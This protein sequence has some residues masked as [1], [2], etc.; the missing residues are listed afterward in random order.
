MSTRSVRC[1]RRARQAARLMLVVVLPQPP[2]WL[3]IAIVR[4]DNLPWCSSRASEPF[5]RLKM[6][7]DS[8]C[9]LPQ[10]PIGEVSAET[11]VLWDRFD[12]HG[13]IRYFQSPLL[14]FQYDCDSDSHWHLRLDL[15]SLARDF[16]SQNSHAKARIG[17][18]Q[19][20]A[21]LH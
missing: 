3:M 12:N 7:P 9:T 10:F 5:R 13:D 15:S 8:F 21:Q 20:D 6:T 1:P 17:I 16:L 18:R 4:I 14:A 19:P 11:L 2:F